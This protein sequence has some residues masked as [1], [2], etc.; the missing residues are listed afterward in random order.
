MLRR[1]VPRHAFTGGKY[2]Q[3][4]DKES[5]R[6]HREQRRRILY[7]AQGNLLLSG[8]AYVLWVDFHKPAAIILASLGAFYGYNRAL[9]Y[10]SRG[11]EDRVRALDSQSE[12]YARQSGK[13]KSDK[14]LV[15]PSRQI[16]DPDFLNIPA[17][18]GKAVYQSKLMTDDSASVG[19]GERNRS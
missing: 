9:V 2:R 12:A 16:D 3:H 18:G 11:D 6:I 8:L 7:D 15:K 10:L 13:L 5:E 19:H 1:C 14:Y 17:F 4:V